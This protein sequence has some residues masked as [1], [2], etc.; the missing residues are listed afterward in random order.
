MSGRGV[1]GFVGLVEWWEDDLTAYERGH[2]S[3]SYRPL[4]GGRNPPDEGD[5]VKLIGIDNKPLTALHIVNALLNFI[6]D[7]RVQ[8]KLILKGKELSV[9][10]RNPLDIHFFFGSVLKIEFKNRNE[11]DGSMQLVIDAC[12]SQIGIASKAKTRLLKNSHLAGE[13]PSHEGYS[14]LV[15]LLERDK[16]FSEANTLC[17]KALKQGWRGD[18]E[19]RIEENLKKIKQ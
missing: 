19:C 13:L 11:H 14:R 4:G 18:W 5:V 17:K 7:Y 8:K 12:N 15:S 2:I 9:S 1:I 10:C 6:S 16:K 3:D